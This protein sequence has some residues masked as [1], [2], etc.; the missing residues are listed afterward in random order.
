MD[1]IR[2]RVRGFLAEFTSPGEKDVQSFIEDIASKNPS[3]DVKDFKK[4]LVT[5]IEQRDGLKAYEKH[6]SSLSTDS[7]AYKELESILR[8]AREGHKNLGDI[9]SV[10]KKAGDFLAAEQGKGN[11]KTISEPKPPAEM[12]KTQH[13]GIAAKLEEPVEEVEGKKD[14]VLKED[15]DKSLEKHP[16]K[17]HKKGRKEK[18]KKHAEEAVQIE[19]PEQAGIKAEI[20]EKTSQPPEDDKTPPAKADAPVM[21][22]KAEA[23]EED[24]P[25]PVDSHADRTEVPAA[26]GM[27]GTKEESIQQPRKEDASAVKTAAAAPAAQA[28]AVRKEESPG[29]PGDGKAPVEKAE[30]PKVQAEDVTKKETSQ[31]PEEKKTPV[32]DTAVVK[33]EAAVK[34]KASD[35]PADGQPAKKEKKHNKKKEA[36]IPEETRLE[37]ESLAGAA[38]P[39]AAQDFLQRLEMDD[40]R[41]IIKEQLTPEKQAVFELLE[42]KLL[43][44]VETRVKKL[45]EMQSS[46]LEEKPPQTLAGKIKTFFTKEIEAVETY[47]AALHGPLVTFGGIQGFNELERY[48]VNEPYAFVVILFD[49]NNNAYLYYAA[50]PT[51]SDFE[52][53]FLK[54]IKDRLKDVLLVENIKDEGDKDKILTN[55]VR[56]L[57]KDYAIDI[58]P[59]TLEKILYYSRRDYIY[60]GKLDPLMHDDRIED[61]SANGHDIPIYLYHKKYTNIPTNIFYTENELNSYVIRLAQRCG[62]HISIAEPM[63]DATMPDGSRIQMTLGTE[64]TSHGATFTIRKFSEIPITPVD[65]IKWNTFSAEEL[66]YLWLCIENN[67]S[68]IY[69]GGTASGK[70]SSLN[71]VSLFIPAQAKIVTLEDTRELKLPHPNWI[72]GVTRDS[73]TADGRGSIDMYELLRAALRQRPEFLLVGEV[74]GKEA[75]TL[76]QAMSTGHTTFSTMHADSVASAIHRL[77]NPPISVPR[78]MIQAL[79]IISI[80]AQTYVNGKRA[81]RNMKLVEITDIDPT[82]RNIRTNDIFVWDPLTDKFLR[83]GE[84]KALNEIMIR[85]GWSPMDLKKELVFRQKILE[86]MVNNKISDFNAIATIIHDYQATPDKVITKL[87]ITL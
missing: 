41:T 7:A 87:N 66:A 3:L 73:F 49:P 65:L 67:K 25:K 79:N 30:A 56:S 46:L 58:S 32:K 14:E 36:E 45:K 77:E 57:I 24:Q 35:K 16:K 51:L 83:V 43:S 23:K 37:I 6:L 10:L 74:R 9:S 26:Q 70:T 28:E 44:D 21:Q 15:A 2:E 1:D 54:E 53:L 5:V 72:P 80:Q 64:V 55:K 17:P 22:E 4:K 42:E 34:E 71:A 27:A 52:D 78:T 76:F 60:F 75:L 18:G 50:E 86:F 29:Q 48:W 82:T 13:N 19:D 47:D 11:G 61:I 40:A 81:R 20:K 62:K 8:V 63:V 59:L 69:A 31:Q 68:L 33:D 84:S 85:R 12:H 39:G 38:S